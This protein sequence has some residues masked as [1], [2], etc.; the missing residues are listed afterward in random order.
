MCKIKKQVLSWNFRLL[1]S[2]CEL[3][4]IILHSSEKCQKYFVWKKYFY[5]PI[6][7]VS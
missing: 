2:R 7:L 5:L 1:C 6:N 3:R 4:N